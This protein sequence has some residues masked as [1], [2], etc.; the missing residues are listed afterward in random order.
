MR[1][2]KTVPALAGE[3]IRPVGSPADEGG[4]EGDSAG[5]GGEDEGGA[6]AVAAAVAVA[7]GGG[8]ADVCDD[9]L[10]AH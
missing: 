2:I 7:L 5:D 3:A 10:G 6:A 9:G 4:D 1:L 8:G